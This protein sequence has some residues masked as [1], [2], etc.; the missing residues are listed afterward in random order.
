MI[1]LT[2]LFFIILALV[3]AD[4]YTNENSIFIEDNLF[5]KYSSSDNYVKIDGVL[6]TP[7]AN[8]TVTFPN[9]YMM[10]SSVEI[11]SSNSFTSFVYLENDF[12]SG[13]YTVTITPYDDL[14]TDDDLVDYFLLT[15]SDSFVDITIGEN[16]AQKCMYVTDNYGNKIEN[17]NICVNPQVTHIPKSF[18]IH[19]LNMDSKTHKMDFG[20]VETDLILPGSE[21][22][23][24][25]DMDGTYDYSCVFH[26]WV[27]GIVSISE[28]PSLTYDI[29]TVSN[30]MPNMDSGNDDNDNNDLSLPEE[31]ADSYLYDTSCTNCY[32]GIVT[33]IV[34]GDTIHVNDEIIRLSLVDTPESRDEGFE[35]ATSYTAKTCPVGMSVLVDIDDLQPQDKYKRSMAKITCADVNLNA[36]LLSSGNAEIYDYFCAKSEFIT[37]SW[38]AEGCG[39]EMDDDVILELPVETIPLQNNTIQINNS[40]AIKHV[41]KSNFV[42]SSDL[43]LIIIFVVLII[44]VMIVFLMKKSK[45]DFNANHNSDENFVYLE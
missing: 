33:K 9:G 28:I 32:V 16:A 43:I 29:P 2:S 41:D 3:I 38:A 15:D 11:S 30:Y 19:F 22:V 7:F 20:I 42:V 13:V 10:H 21:A 26:P 8:M 24:F 27:G 17:G 25:L 14:F 23:V 44:I 12:E 34:D 31:N 5:K 4:D 35:K 18:G 36:A 45:P 6:V 1:F 39:I 40:S 37:E